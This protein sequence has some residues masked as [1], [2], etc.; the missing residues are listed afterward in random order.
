MNLSLKKKQRSVELEKLVAC[1]PGYE[2]KTFKIV[3]R[4]TPKIYHKSSIELE[5]EQKQ[6]IKLLTV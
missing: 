4:L 5:L 6:R 2:N 1:L 3:F